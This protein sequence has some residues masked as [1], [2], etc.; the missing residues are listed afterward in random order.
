MTNR[1]P[2]E[3]SPF[4]AFWM[5][6]NDQVSELWVTKFAGWKECKPATL[7]ASAPVRGASETSE[8]RPVGQYEKTCIGR[9]EVLQYALLVVLQDLTR[10]EQAI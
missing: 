9:Q 2:I 4:A 5:I 3:R 10:P 8:G 6:G 7:H 1:I